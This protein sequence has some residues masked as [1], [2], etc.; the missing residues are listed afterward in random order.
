MTAIML[1]LRPILYLTDDLS[2]LSRQRS[3]AIAYDFIRARH[4]ARVC[5]GTERNTF[6]VTY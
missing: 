5:A 1:E 2:T 3:I 4:F 6:S